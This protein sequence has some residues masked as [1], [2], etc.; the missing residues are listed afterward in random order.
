[1]HRRVFLKLCS[2]LTAGGA[3]LR[4]LPTWASTEPLPLKQLANEAGLSVIGTQVGRGHLTNPA[5][6]AIVVRNFNEITPGQELK[7]AALRPSPDVF[8]WKN[9]DWMIDFAEKS[10]LSTHGH[11][12][13]WNVAN[14]AWMNTVIDRSNAEQYLR[15]HITT[16]VSRYRGR[17]S[18]WDVVNEPITVSGRAELKRGIWLNTL[19]PSYVDIAFHATKEADPTALRILNLQS[20]EQSGRGFDAFRAASLQLVTGLVRRGVPL[21]AI[22]LQS[23]LDGVLP[24]VSTARDGFVKAL[25]GLGLEVC[26]SELDVNDHFSGSDEVRKRAVGQA[27]E[28]F[29]GDIIPR[30]GLKRLLFWTLTDQDVWYNDSV[31]FKRADGKPQYSGLFDAR[32]QPNPAFSDVANAL[33]RLAGGHYPAKSLGDR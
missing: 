9:A 20:T 2:E 8:M 7:W 10:N 32:M 33:K 25:R 24:V 26:V 6:A 23:H 31:R 19:G 18:A 1:M 21:Q 27:Y 3:L 13:C 5:I 30:A 17:I 22:G 28:V 4:S 14:P 15:E 16:V 29:I 11:N 12:L